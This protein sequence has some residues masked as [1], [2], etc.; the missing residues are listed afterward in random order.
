VL[1]LNEFGFETINQFGDKPGPRRRAALQVI[2]ELQKADLPSAI[3]LV[4][5]TTGGLLS[6]LQ[7]PPP[8][9]PASS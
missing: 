8:P 6:A 5:S 7:T 1:V 3:S 4:A 9:Y 2:D